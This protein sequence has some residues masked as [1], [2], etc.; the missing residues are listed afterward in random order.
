MSI[1]AAFFQQPAISFAWSMVSSAPLLPRRMAT[2]QV[3]FAAYFRRSSAMWARP[4][5]TRTL[6]YLTAT[7]LP[8]GIVLCSR[9]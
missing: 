5:A 3:A 6:S 4:S 9:R 1:T 7:P 8:V 2:G